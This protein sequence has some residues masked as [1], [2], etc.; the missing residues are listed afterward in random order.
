GGAIGLNSNNIGMVVSDCS[1]FRTTANLGGGVALNFLNSDISVSQCVFHETSSLSDGGG[2]YLYSRNKQVSVSDCVFNNTVSGDDGGGIYLFSSNY[3]FSVEGCLFSG[4]KTSDQGGA[5]Y[6]SSNNDFSLV[7]RSNI[8]RC[9]AVRG[10]AIVVGSGHSLVQLVFVACCSFDNNKAGFGGA[11]Y[12]GEY[13]NGIAVAASSF[14]SN[15]GDYGAALYITQFNGGVSI[16]DSVLMLNSASVQGGALFVLV[17]DLVV[18]DTTFSGNDASSSGAV[19][20][21]VGAISVLNCVFVGNEGPF[22]SHGGMYVED[23][24][25]VVVRSTE[26]ISNR[27]ESGGA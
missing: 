4:C 6:M 2:I 25:S 17:E 27:A 5:M 21:R 11:V 20:A 3:G 13:H 18:R 12:F 16:T 22:G 24:A 26:F 7:L 23:A 9:F 14:S 8:T 10:G 19:Y 15:S 1:F